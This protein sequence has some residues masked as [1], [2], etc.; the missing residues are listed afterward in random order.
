MISSSGN[1][2]ENGARIVG[3]VTGDG[4]ADVIKIDFASGT[5]MLPPSK[6]IAFDEVVGLPNT[7]SATKFVQLTD[8]T[9]SGKTDLIGLTESGEIIVAL[10]SG[11]NTF[12]TVVSWGFVS[13]VMPSGIIPE[14][15][16][17]AFGSMDKSKGN[18]L[19]IFADSG[20]YVAVN[21]FNFNEAVKVVDTLGAK[22]AESG[23]VYGGTNSDNLAL[24]V[25]SQATVLTTSLV[26]GTQ[27]FTPLFIMV[28]VR[29]GV[30]HKK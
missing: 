8:L 22:D 16:N 23:H 10:N 21:N 18:D 7:F 25:T 12:N 2:I 20:V 5:V 13:D 4:K 27:L 24:L 11:D 19:V 3:D 9:G 28:T 15:T 29:F 1:I 6:G 17:V 30:P 26:M 14:Q